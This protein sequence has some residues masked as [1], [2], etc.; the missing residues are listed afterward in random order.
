[1]IDRAGRPR[2]PLLSWTII[3]IYP[4]RLECG[5]IW[6]VL[7]RVETKHTYRRDSPLETLVLGLSSRGV[8]GSPLLHDRL[9]RLYKILRWLQRRDYCFLHR[10]FLRAISPTWGVSNRCSPSENQEREFLIMSTDKWCSDRHREHIRLVP[11]VP[12]SAHLRS[13]CLR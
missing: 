12:R 9:F 8:R 10:F 7:Q 11:E 6:T 3:S 2:L 1:M 5:P 13:N 4:H